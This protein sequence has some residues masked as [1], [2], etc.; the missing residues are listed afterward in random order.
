V[1]FVIKILA[2]APYSH[3]NKYYWIIFVRLFFAL[4]YFMF[5]AACVVQQTLA[6]WRLAGIFIDTNK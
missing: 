6:L 3:E 1:L 4:F 2:I 5:V